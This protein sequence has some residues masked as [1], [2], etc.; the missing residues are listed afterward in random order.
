[1]N[2]IDIREYEVQVANLKY[3]AKQEQ[4]NMKII[5]DTYTEFVEAYTE[6]ILSNREHFDFESSWS[7]D[8]EN[9]HTK[10]PYY[11]KVDLGKNQISI[12]PEAFKKWCSE[13]NFVI[14]QVLESLFD[15]G[16]LSINKGRERYKDKNVKFE[17]V[18]KKCYQ[19]INIFDK[20]IEIV[21]ENVKPDRVQPEQ[22]PVVE[23]IEI[24]PETLFDNNIDDEIPF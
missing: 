21:Y 14:N 4:D 12:F 23:N 11:G 3:F 18:N 17:G 8:E 6:F 9:K 15:N 16:K 13:N 7:V 20:D 10:I 19:I 1:M 5:K 24:Q 22:A 2:L